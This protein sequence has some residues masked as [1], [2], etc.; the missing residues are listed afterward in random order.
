[1]IVLS[2]PTAYSGWIFM[3]SRNPRH[4]ISEFLPP[5]QWDEYGLLKHSRSAV[6]TANWYRAGDNHGKYSIHMPHEI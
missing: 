2:K 1:M 3:V 5:F 4:I 6:S